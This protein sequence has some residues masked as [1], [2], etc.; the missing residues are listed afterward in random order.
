LPGIPSGTQEIKLNGYR[1]VAVKA[2][3]KV[4]LFLRRHKSF[5]EHNPFV[6]ALHDL[7]EGAVVE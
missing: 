4:E 3:G 2:I 1:A 5:D 7:P 6:E